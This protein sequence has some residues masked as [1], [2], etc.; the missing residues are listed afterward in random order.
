[1]PMRRHMV[2][3]QHLKLFDRKKLIMNTQTK[4]ILLGLST[5]AA[6]LLAVPA[7]MSASRSPYELGLEAVRDYRYSEAL[8]HFQAAAEQGERGA[9]RNLGLMLLY[10]DQLYGKEVPRNQAQAKRWLQAA[11]SDGCEVSAFMLKVM[12]Q[13]G[14]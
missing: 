12:A 11:A 4:R 1:M 5:V 13:H 7:A 9:R 14:R 3:Q 2:T 10:G 6:L 8:M